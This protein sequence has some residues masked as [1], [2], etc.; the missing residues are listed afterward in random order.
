MI[1]KTLKNRHC[2]LNYVDL[3]AQNEQY[4]LSCA[5]KMTCLFSGFTKELDNFKTIFTTYDLTTWW[6]SKSDE[7]LSTIVCLVYISAF[8][9]IL[10][11]E[12]KIQLDCNFDS[13]Y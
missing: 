8:A 2:F 10:F 3:D 9:K 11:Y 7:S 12:L 5:L 1:V 6:L 13:D 4:H